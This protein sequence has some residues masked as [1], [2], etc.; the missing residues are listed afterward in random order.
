MTNTE[1]RQIHYVVMLGKHLSFTLAAKELGITQSALTRSIQAIERHAGTRLFDRDRGRV[2]L[3]EVGRTYLARAEALLQDARDLDRMLQ[4][5]AVGDIGEVRFGMTSAVARAIL[6]EILVQELAHRPQLRQTI[7]NR[8]PETM[9]ELVQAE[10]LEFCVCSERPIAPISLRSTII[11]RMPLALLV[12]AGHPASSDRPTGDLRAYPLLLSSQPTDTERIARL[13]RPL[14]LSPPSIVLDD[15][16]ILHHIALNSD[17][18]WLTAPAAAAVG[19]RSGSLRQLPLPPGGDFRFR[20]VLYS[21][22]RRTL[23]PAAR[24]LAD[25]MR[26]QAARWG[27][28]R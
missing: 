12:R 26:A 24:R 18:I 15:L 19:L 11:G 20:V 22:Q 8:A 10:A 16:G 2:S 21:H 17:A 6:P 4:Q 14:L 13:V 5:S 25:M 3:T 7:V 23:S 9:I 28:T 1:L 27:S